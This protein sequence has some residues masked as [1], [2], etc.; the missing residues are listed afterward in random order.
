V[1]SGRHAAVEVALHDELAG[2]LAGRVRSVLTVGMIGIVVGV[3]IDALRDEPRF[4]DLVVVKAV[5]FTVYAAFIA[6]L[7]T[8]RGRGWWATVATATVALAC[9]CAVLSA[10]GVITGEMTMA[11]MMYVVVTLGGAAYLPWGMMAQLALVASS[12]AILLGAMWIAPDATFVG[13]NLTVS[14]LAAGGVSVLMAYSLE[15]QRLDRKRSEIFQAAH[16]QLLERVAADAPLERILEDVLC[17]AEQ[18]LPGIRG[19]VLLVDAEAGALRVGASLG[20]SDP[21]VRILG[22][23][24]LADQPAGCCSAA[25]NRA[26]RVVVANL[27]TYGPSS[28]AEHVALAEGI[29]A[30]WAQPVITSSGAVV[31]VLAAY[32]GEPG[33]PGPRE[34]EVLEF[35]AHIAGIAIE[36]REARRQLERY[37]AA[38]DDARS[39][40][41][42]QA[43]KLRE[44]ATELAQARDQALASTRAK[45]EFLAN[46]S[47]EI[48]TPMNGIIGMAT[49]LLDTE[50]TD[51]QYEYATTIRSCGDSLLTVLN[52][53]LDFSKIEA[54][55]LAIECGDLSL[56]AVVEDVAELLAPRAREKGLELVSVLPPDLPER[57][58]GDAARIRQILTNLLGNA[59]KFTER[60]EVV[61]EAT[62][63][64]DVGADARIRLAVHDTGIGIPAERH[65]AV[66]ESF[67]QADGSM[68]RRFGGTGLGLTISRQLVDL[69]GGRIG[70]ESTPQVGSTFWVELELEKASNRGSPPLR[71]AASPRGRALVADANATSRRALGMALAALGLATRE[72]ETGAGAVEAAR[73]AAEAMQPFD[74]I[75]LDMH[76]PD[77][78]AGETAWRLSGERLLG[79]A[80]LVL[81]A[82][83]ID[84]PAA[85]RMSAAA[86]FAGIVAKPFRQ[87][88]LQAM[89]A[90]AGWPPPTVAAGSAV[91]SAAAARSEVAEGRAAADAVDRRPIAEASDRRSAAVVSEPLGLRVLVAEDNIVNQRV[92]LRMLRRLGCEAEAV[93][94]GDEAFAA[95]RCGGFDVVLMDCQMPVMDGFEATRAIRALEA[96][97]AA[98]RTAIVALTAHAMRGDRERCLEAG[99]DDYLSKPIHLED[100][101]TRLRR[102]RDAR[103]GEAATSLRQ[104]AGER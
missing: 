79:G 86:G 81:L 54:G 29:R 98:R 11:A 18:Q 82:P 32:V 26:A 72:A 87:S 9:V 24:R 95:V 21:Y 46:M 77:L 91:G 19:A 89:L 43:A 92:V 76:L 31:G 50:I 61:V 51:E 74:V 17:A 7:R 36:R 5:A 23:T 62:L 88:A 70:L 97:S 59:I 66:F 28:E 2:Q 49:L 100:I 3:A 63:L 104:A 83:V 37:V 75:L 20:L 1:T 48:R 34:V 27:A 53:I 30:C 94:N 78:D 56:R 6:V 40:A 13:V 69:M 90:R 85:R 33:S 71:L 25:A 14:V 101:A 16:K 22:A 45:S 35:A 8:V 39:Q 55:K 96:S 42:E 52:D 15:R 102:V 60:G 80:R 73:V 47:H 65:G 64:S 103:R 68:T 4:A 57:L 99:M 58:R 67:T 38:L 93:A 44:Q 12:S 10:I 84:L 41:E